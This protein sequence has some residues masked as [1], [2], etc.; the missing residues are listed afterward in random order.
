MKHNG[1]KHTPKKSVKRMTLCWCMALKLLKAAS[2][3]LQNLVK[4]FPF[5][6]TIW[7]SFSNKKYISPIAV[8]LPHFK[9]KN[10]EP[11]SLDKIRMYLNLQPALLVPLLP[12]LLKVKQRTERTWWN[13]TNKCETK[14]KTWISKNKKSRMQENTKRTKDTV[15]PLQIYIHIINSIFTL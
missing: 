5:C 14:L 3:I 9:N 11:V 7:G 8:N 4:L 6:L 1:T 2:I 10:L 12:F 15:G 13:T